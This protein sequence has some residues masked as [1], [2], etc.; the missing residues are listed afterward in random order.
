M[1]GGPDKNKKQDVGYD[2]FN[3]DE[4]EGESQHVVHSLPVNNGFLK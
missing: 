2:S 4:G 1:I 3:D